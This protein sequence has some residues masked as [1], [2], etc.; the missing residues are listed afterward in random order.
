MYS[1][2]IQVKNTKNL[3]SQWK[4]SEKFILGFQV[5]A[6]LSTGAKKAD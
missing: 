6:L 4:R 1:I 2:A 3:C 5:L